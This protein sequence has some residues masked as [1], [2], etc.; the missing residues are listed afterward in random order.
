MYHE[1]VHLHS[2][3]LQQSGHGRD[4]VKTGQVER[5]DTA[6][7]AATDKFSVGDDTQQPVP[8]SLIVVVYSGA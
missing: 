5:G 4:V 3:H 2:G 1:Q 7:H 8:G 6:G